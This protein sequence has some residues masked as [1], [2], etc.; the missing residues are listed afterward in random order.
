MNAAYVNPMKI[1]DVKRS[2]YNGTNLL[3]DCL[4]VNDPQA[5]QI[6]RNVFLFILSAFF[7]FEWLNLL[8]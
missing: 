1:F 8:W 6:I 4:S 7:C 3:K 5:Y 2:K